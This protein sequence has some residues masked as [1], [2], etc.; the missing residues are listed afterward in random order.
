MTANQS[1]IDAYNHIINSSVFRM[2]GTTINVADALVALADAV[3]HEDA[4]NDAWIYLGESGPC[5]LPDLIVGAYWALA[6]WHYGQWSDE[7]R[8]LCA[9]G[10]VFDPKHT[11]EPEPEDSAFDAYDAFDSYFSVRS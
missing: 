9:L 3:L 8:A 2:D 11:G 5:T 1:T 10:N 6:R 7:Y 4:D